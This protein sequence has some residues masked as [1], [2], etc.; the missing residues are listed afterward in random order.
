MDDEDVSDE[1]MMNVELG[2]QEE[3]EKAKTGDSP[4]REREIKGE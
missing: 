3:S 2:K 1:V 4:E